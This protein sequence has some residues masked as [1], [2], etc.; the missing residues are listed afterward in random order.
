MHG[1]LHGVLLR[2]HA[3]LRF[4]V[5]FLQGEEGQRD[6]QWLHGAGPVHVWLLRGRWH[7]LPSDVHG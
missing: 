7:L 2:R 3:I 1:V 5:R 4:Y 6:R